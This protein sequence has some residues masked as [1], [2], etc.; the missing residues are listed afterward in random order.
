M[1]H[2]DEGLIRA[3]ADGEAEDREGKLAVHLSACPRCASHLGEQEEARALLADA[4]SLLD[5]P[6]HLVEARARFHRAREERSTIET[7]PKRLPRLP[8]R[9][10]AVAVFL[11]VG[12]VAAMPNSPFRRWVGTGI[13]ALGGRLPSGEATAPAEADPG[14]PSVGATVILAQGQVELRLLETDENATLRVL[15]VE[16]SQAAILAPQ[17]TRFRA[18]TGILEAHGAS[19]EI[20]LEI[21]RS[22]EHVEVH[23]NGSLFLL[24]RGDVLELPGPVTGR[25]P[26]EIRFGPL[27]READSPPGG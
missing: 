14:T 1:P 25:S 12:G 16:G 11:V 5:R 6:P 24:K 7:L 2:P 27:N 21:P 18:E 15:L 19:G 13:Q 26:E 22:S 4:L 10:A 3:F 17:G 20:T 9:A 23:V 8:L